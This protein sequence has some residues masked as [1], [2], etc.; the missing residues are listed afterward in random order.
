[1]H[2]LSSQGDRD[3]PGVSPAR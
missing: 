2:D 1:M 3:A